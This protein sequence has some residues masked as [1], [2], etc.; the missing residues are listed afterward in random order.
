MEVKINQK[1]S[2]KHINKINKQ[3]IL[4]KKINLKIN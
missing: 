3:I 1:K 2:S 4:I